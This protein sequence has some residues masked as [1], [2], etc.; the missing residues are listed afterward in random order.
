MALN[1]VPLSPAGAQEP[2]HSYAE[3]R[4]DA[5]FSHAN[6]G[7]L[8][9]G[10]QIPLGFYTRF[11]LDVAGGA[12]RERGQS[13]GTARGDAIMRFLLDPF[14]ETRWALSAG[15][16]V[17]VRYVDSHGWRPFLAV[18]LDVEGRRSGRITPAFQLGLG[19]GVRLG[20]A[21]RTSGRAYR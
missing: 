20:M 12:S 9:A 19:G 13:L 5:V 4:A 18:L 7:L 21:L 10:V 16:G 1:G 2:L 14:R 17:S 8:G 3:L 15:A 11:G 6:E